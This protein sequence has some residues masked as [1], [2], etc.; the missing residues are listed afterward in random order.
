M[1]RLYHLELPHANAQ[2]FQNPTIVAG[3][4]GVHKRPSLNA[5]GNVRCVSKNWDYTN[6]LKG[7]HFLVF[8]SW[9]AW[10]TETRGLEPRK[11]QVDR[12]L[13]RRQRH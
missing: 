1:E 9:I 6:C 4:N 5:R 8:E 13:G 11:Q 2:L 12:V 7:S 3:N 10:D